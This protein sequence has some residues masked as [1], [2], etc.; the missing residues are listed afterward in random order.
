MNESSTQH[1]DVSIK[2]DPYSD[3]GVNAEL[4]DKLA[5]WLARDTNPVKSNPF[6]M[7]TSGIGGFAGSF[8]LSLSQLKQPEL[9][10]STDGV[11]TKLL[12]GLEHNLLSGLGQDLVAM[13]VNDLYTVGATPLFFLD[14][15]ATG[16]LDADQF[17]SILT[18][19]KSSCVTCSMDLMGGE[20]AEM[21]GLYQKG[22]F[23]L[24]GFVV[25]VV[26]KPKKL[27]PELVKEG[28][29]VFG[30]ESSGFH[31]NGFSLIRK[32]LS[33][34]GASSDLVKKLMQPTKLYPEILTCLKEFGCLIHGAANITGGGISGNLPRALPAGL[35][36]RLSFASL[37]VKDWMRQL[38]ESSGSSL[39]EVEPVF[40]LG[41][42]FQMIVD[43]TIRE[44]F[45]GF[46]K[47]HG[48]NATLLGT[49][50]R[51][52]EGREARVIYES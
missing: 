9:V 6:G 1:P 45:I 47:H 23:D 33:K 20:T 30:W 2:S 49:I 36:A 46:S 12:L 13:C 40:N 16:K 35:S 48:L 37:P 38:I 18:S 52:K 24:A 21:P 25:G 5:D 34:S 10:A 4:G 8:A 29:L 51:E 32:W 22:H 14:Y 27:R 19:I 44:Q 43:P 41:V 3:S 42:G 39:K 31:S 7:L 28:D 50:V 11:G 26:D 15:F 17:K